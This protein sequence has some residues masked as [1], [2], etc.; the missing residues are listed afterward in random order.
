[1]PRVV[2]AMR[3]IQEGEQDLQKEKPM[4]LKIFTMKHYSS[5]SFDNHYRAGKLD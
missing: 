2:E 1:M 3:I 4:L 5:A